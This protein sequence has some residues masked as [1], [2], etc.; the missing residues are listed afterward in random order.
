MVM[1][2]ISIMS[3]CAL[4]VRM[5]HMQ[6]KYLWPADYLVSQTKAMKVSRN[7]VYE[8]AYA[9]VYFNA[10]G[11]VR[12]AQTIQIDNRV[13]VSELGEGKLVFK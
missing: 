1:M 13:V 4:P 12:S 5:K 3:L 2:V 8:S 6:D 11:N 7:V 10:K 9:T